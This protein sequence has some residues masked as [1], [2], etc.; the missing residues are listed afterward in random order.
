MGNAEHLNITKEGVEA[1][2]AWQVENPGVRLELSHGDL[3]KVDL[4]RARLA[5]ADLSRADLTGANLT[6]ADLTGADLTRADLTMARLAGA[7]L[8]QVNLYRATFTAAD[9]AGAD[10]TGAK[11]GFTCVSDCDMFV[12]EGLGTA[13]HTVPSSV[14]IDTLTRTLRTNRGRFTKELHK[15]F[16]ARV[17][18]RSV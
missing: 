15:F 4:T 14:G 7:R 3:A 10:F 11:F 16:K 18:P 9:L 17:S 12:A 8:A 2:E 5:D 13:E 6:D 1:L